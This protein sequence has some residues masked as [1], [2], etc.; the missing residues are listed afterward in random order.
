MNRQKFLA[1]LSRLLVYMTEED[2]AEAVRRVG[3]LFD[4]AGPAG[5]T[6]LLASLGSPTRTAIA[7]S[8]GYEPGKLPDALPKVVPA[9]RTPAP[10]K[11]TEP[12]P[13]ELWSD[14]PDFEPPAVE[15]EEETAPASEP[16]PEEEPV[17][18]ETPDFI[19]EAAEEPAEA[20]AP[21]I[22]RTMPLGLG[23]PL[24]VLV[25]AALGVPLCALTLA[26]T[27]VL[28]LPGAAALVGAYLALAGGLWCTG[29][30]ADAV[31][32]FGL[33]AV[34]LALGLLLLALGLWA[35]VILWRLYRQGVG[36]VAGELLGRKV[37]A[38][39]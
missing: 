26:L 38:D 6:A 14:L 1:E 33:A 8:R 29:Y 2:R 7:L 21:V 5:E 18:A 16:A 9:P 32:L 24:F 19:K 3:A 20:P 4:E 37:T 22:E 25:F 28:L 15:G 23:I 27:V 11:A 10:A 30:M 39:A 13:D 12:K 35:A 17:P 36:W 31:L 34:I